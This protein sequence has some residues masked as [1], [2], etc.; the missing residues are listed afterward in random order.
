M[1]LNV[2]CRM[3]Q[4]H[5]VRKSSWHGHGTQYNFEIN[6]L[7]PILTIKKL[8]LREV[9]KFAPSQVA[10]TSKL[11]LYTLYTIHP[12]PH[13][14]IFLTRNTCSLLNR[15]CA[16]GVCLRIAVSL[17]SYLLSV[18]PCPIFWFQEN[19]YNSDHLS[20]MVPFLKSIFSLDPCFPSA[21]PTWLNVLT[22]ISF[23]CLD[24]WGFSGSLA[25]V[26]PHHFYS[27]IFPQ[28]SWAKEPMI[29]H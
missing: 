26:W 20:G 2:N 29:P 25:L 28:Y 27:Q 15:H 1:T 11:Y 24:G 6:I 23:M 8:G 10:K 9:E 12:P 17:V 21:W 16:S 3:P 13:T 18:L 14:H 4:T 19:F 5:A 7:T 22:S